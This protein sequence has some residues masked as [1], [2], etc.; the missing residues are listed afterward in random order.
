LVSRATDVNGRV[1]P[2]EEEL[3]TKKSFLEH[4]AQAPRKVKIT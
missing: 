4:N 2:T 3:G 1:Q